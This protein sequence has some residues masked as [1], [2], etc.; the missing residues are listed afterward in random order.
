[1]ENNY[2]ESRIFKADV[3]ELDN[4]FEYSSRLLKILEFTSREITLINTALEEIFVNVAKYAYD[5]TGFVEVTLS[6]DKSSVKFVFRDSGKPFNPL[7]KQDPNITA[8]SDEREIGGLGI[9]MVK[10]IMDEVTYDYINNQNV[11]TLIKNRKQ[12]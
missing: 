8:S 11:L 9:Y 5:D 3:A 12:N 2:L 10:Q 1:M 4:L 7:A 6:N